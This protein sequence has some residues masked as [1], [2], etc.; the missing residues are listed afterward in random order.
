MYK[1]R[2]D[3]KVAI[4]GWDL[5]DSGKLFQGP[6][7]LELQKYCLESL[8][9]SLETTLVQLGWDEREDLILYEAFSDVKGVLEKNATIFMYVFMEEIPAIHSW[10]N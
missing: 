10:E 4:V 7:T 6:M 3:L 2:L 1:S 8:L 9:E 5:M